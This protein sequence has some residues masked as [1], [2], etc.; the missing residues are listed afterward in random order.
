MALR[1]STG[2]RNA[3]MGTDGKGFGEVMNGGFIHIYTGAQPLSA[4]YVETGTKLAIISSTSGTRPEDGVTFGAT[5]SGVLTI[6]STPWTG[7]ILATGVAGWFR[8]CASSGTGGYVGTSGT[9]IR[10]DGAVGIA[11]AD[12][13][14]T[15][16]SLTEAATITLTAA[17]ITQPAE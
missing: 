16:T 15:H 5:A 12:L 2:L 4:D 6:G 13:N 11:G 1:L 7:V 3:L 10:F 14:L 8:F 17:N 9:A